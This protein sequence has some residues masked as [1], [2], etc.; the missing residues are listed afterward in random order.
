VDL[1]KTLTP[2]RAASGK[3]KGAATRPSI[4]F[5]GRTAHATDIRREKNNFSNYQQ[6]AFSGQV[7]VEIASL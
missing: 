5:K 7:A 4:I 2:S 3:E 1:W 6:R